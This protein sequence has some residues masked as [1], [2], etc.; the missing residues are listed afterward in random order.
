M[1][2]KP[3]AR[4]ATGLLLLS[5][6]GI[7]QLAQA[8][9]R[10]DAAMV[11]RREPAI[12]TQLNNGTSGPLAAEAPS[13]ERPTAFT[14]PECDGQP[15]PAGVLANLL[16]RLKG[17]ASFEPARLCPMPSEEDAAEGHHD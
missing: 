13:I 8:G 17:Q 4:W 12:S 15:Q 9:D 10:P 16:N 7:A 3:W 6:T 1:K 2:T 14:S 5:A 11:A